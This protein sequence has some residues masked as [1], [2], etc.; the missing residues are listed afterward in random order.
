MTWGLPSGGVWRTQPPAGGLA[1]RDRATT[2]KGGI[3]VKGKIDTR[4]S[5]IVG[6][7]DDFP[8]LCGLP[9]VVEGRAARLEMDDRGWY[10]IDGDGWR[11]YHLEG[12]EVEVRY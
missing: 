2:H 10:A 7:N 11:L 5:K 6:R 1:R 12:R 8:M 3:T 4:N 9:V